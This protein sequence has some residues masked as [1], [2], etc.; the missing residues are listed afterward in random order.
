MNNNQILRAQSFLEKGY[1]NWG[2]EVLEKELQKEPN[3]AFLKLKIAQTY[4]RFEYLPTDERIKNL[5]KAKEYCI[6][7]LN[8]KK[9]NFAKL[10]LGRIELLLGNIQESKNQFSSLLE[11]EIGT[12]AILELAKIELFL[13][14][15]K[16]AKSHFLELLNTGKKSEALVQ[17]I[18]IYIKQE[19]YISAYK[20]Y[21]EYMTVASQTNLLDIRTLYYLNYQL[22]NSENQDST[23]YFSKQLVQ[24]KESRAISHVKKHLCPLRERPGH[25]YFYK[26]ITAESIFKQAKEQIE[27][28]NADSFTVVD[29]YILKQSEEISKIEGNPTNLI[30]VIT[31]LNNKN[32]LTIHP[33]Y[34]TLYDIQ[35]SVKEK[36]KK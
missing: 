11:T 10:E 24:Y 14:N 7:L 29:K 22:G 1:F 20:Y 8:A 36:M 16:E 21:K 25:T 12:D 28:I 3:N 5:N 32:I 13:Q 30:Q 6:Q 23:Y 35:Q 26:G 27:M 9:K 34:N 31:Q 2:I 18:Y 17:L 19:D 4:R 15:I 33:F